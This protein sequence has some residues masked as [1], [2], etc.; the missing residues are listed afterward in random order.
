MDLFELLLCELQ[1]ME[2]GMEMEM[3]MKST[4]IIYENTLSKRVSSYH[5]LHLCTKRFRVMEMVLVLVLV[6]VCMSCVCVASIHHRHRYCVWM[7]VHIRHSFV[8]RMHLCPLD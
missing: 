1:S 2:M 8:M 7:C 5:D 4:R 3:G 6:L